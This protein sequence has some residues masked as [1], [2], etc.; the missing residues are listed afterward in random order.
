MRFR[1]C[2]RRANVSTR[3]FR[4]AAVGSVPPTPLRA[5]GRVD[6]GPANSWPANADRRVAA[7]NGRRSPERA[8]RAKRAYKNAA[9]TRPPGQVANLPGSR[10]RG[11]WPGRPEPALL[12]EPEEE[13]EDRKRWHPCSSIVGSQPAADSANV[14]KTADQGNKPGKLYA[15]RTPLVECLLFAIGKSLSPN[16]LR[17]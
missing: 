6:V 14:K 9:T 15:Q 8:K 4:L 11:R 16:M 2:G 1:I 5:A 12:A 10:R 17:S 13:P 3:G 7:A